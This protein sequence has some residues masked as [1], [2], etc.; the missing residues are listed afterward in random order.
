MNTPKLIV[1]A[2]LLIMIVWALVQMALDL[3]FYSKNNWDFDK[4]RVTKFEIYNGETAD[5]K[6]VR[7]KSR[8]YTYLGVIL[9]G[10]TVVYL[11]YFDLLPE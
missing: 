5:D 9:I 6:P 11:V 1:I 10:A 4:I 3:L 2:L 8:I 7:G